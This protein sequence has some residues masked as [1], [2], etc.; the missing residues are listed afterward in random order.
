MVF[1]KLCV[2][3]LCMKVAS[4]LEG[5]RMLATANLLPFFLLRIMTLVNIFERRVFDNLEPKR[6]RVKAKWNF[7][8]AKTT[9]Q[10][11]SH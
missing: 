1:I 6:G 10:I 7:E 8:L 4:A 3:V 9:A 11:S 2:V 5:L